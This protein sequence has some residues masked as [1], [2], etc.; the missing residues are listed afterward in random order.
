MNNRRRFTRSRR[1]RANRLH[2]QL[3][4]VLLLAGGA[5]ARD[6]LRRRCHENIGIR[7]ARD[8]IRQAVRLAF[9]RIV[10]GTDC[11]FGLHRQRPI[12][13]RGLGAGVWKAGGGAWWGAAAGGAFAGGGVAIIPIRS[14]PRAK[15][16]AP[17]LN[18]RCARGENI[19]SLPDD[20]NIH[21]DSNCR[22]MNTEKP[23]L[24]SAPAS[25]SETADS[26]A[27]TTDACSA[28]DGRRLLM[29]LSASNH[30][31]EVVERRP[32]AALGVDGPRLT[33]GSRCPA[34]ESIACPA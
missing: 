23:Q 15:S 24:L 6:L 33:T 26:G 34:R 21:R 20:I 29:S 17:S 28:T 1:W 11:Q 13:H 2:L 27:L 5:F 32:A 7:H 10:H 4:F 22:V 16:A 3:L 12:F 31:R 9:Q 19:R 8:V 25:R 14:P 30:H 18:I